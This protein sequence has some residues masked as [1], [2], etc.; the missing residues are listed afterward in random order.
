MSSL[1]NYLIY[2][3]HICIGN[4]DDDSKLTEE[5]Q[6]VHKELREG[7]YGR[8]LNILLVGMTGVGKSSLIN[9]WER[10]PRL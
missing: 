4:Q 3:N 6:Q 8:R 7:T 5:A 10:V 1:N 2:S 9:R